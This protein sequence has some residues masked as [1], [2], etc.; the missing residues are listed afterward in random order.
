MANDNQFVMKIHFS[1][2]LMEAED[3]Q[4]KDALE[5]EFVMRFLNVTELLS[6]TDVAIELWAEVMANLTE[7]ARKD[8]LFLDNDASDTSPLQYVAKL[9]YSVFNQ[10]DE[11]GKAGLEQ[12]FAIR[13]LNDTEIIAVDVILQQAWAVAMGKLRSLSAEQGL[14]LDQ[15]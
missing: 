7:V 15:D 13:F 11:D 10:A 14:F 3:D 4:N 12:K 2:D 9:G 8:G 5:Q 1:V 6:V